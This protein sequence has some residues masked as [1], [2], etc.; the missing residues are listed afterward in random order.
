[1]RKNFKTNLFQLATN[2]RGSVSLIEAM[3]ARG[4]L[5]RLRTKLRLR[6][7][8]DLLLYSDGGGKALSVI[9]LFV[10]VSAVAEMAIFSSLI[11]FLAQISPGS[12]QTVLENEAVIAILAY[13]VHLTEW[14]SLDLVFL[15][16]IV[17]MLILR[18][19]SR[20]FVLMLNRR[21]MSEIEF[22]LRSKLISS[23][24]NAEYLCTDRVVLG[25]LLK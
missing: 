8:S 21:G 23:L 15:I 9:F 19:L 1:M 10:G 24:L 6:L 22:N 3:K 7:W 18:E 13:F 12:G 16:L 25:C 20:F 11:I 14:I 5:T 17:L 2:K 4:V